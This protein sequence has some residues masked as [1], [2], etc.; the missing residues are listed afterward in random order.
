[1]KYST[2]PSSQ[3][4]VYHCKARGIK[5]I[6]ISP[7]SR[8]APLTIGFTEDPFFKCFSIVDERCAAFFALGIAQQL[9]EP[10]V[11]LCTSGSALLNYYPAISE[12]FYSDIPL[13]VISAD[14]PP[15]KVDVGDG[16]TIRQENVF[17]NHI[18]YG[19]NLKL[20]VSHA[21]DKIRKYDALSLMGTDVGIAQQ[22]V[23]EFNDTALD[24]AL[25]LAWSQ[26]SPVHINVPFEEPLYDV[27]TET[28]LIP[29]VNFVRDNQQ[30]L[31]LGKLKESVEVWNGS[32]RKIILVGVNFPN[33]VEQKYLEQL[34][35]DPSVIV[36]TECT[37]N[38]H[39][40]NFF[41]SIDSII[42]PIEKSPE[43]E[44]LFKQ[45]QPD[46][47]LTFG[48]LI[49]S[50]KIKAFL[51]EYSPKFHWHIDPQKAPNTFF[52]LTHHFQT[53]PNR[54]FEKLLQVSSG[55]QSDYQQYWT[56]FK[57][58]YIARREQYL[59]EIPFSDMLAFYRI[60]GSIPKDYQLQLG[61]S[62]TVRYGQL[63]DL[64]QCINVFCNRGTSGIDGSTS[65]AIGAALYSEQP[66]LLVTGDLSFLY[67]SNGLWNKYI[68]PDFRIIVINNGGGGIF[69][70]LPGKDKTDNF[71][72]FFETTHQIDLALIAKAY[73]FDF[74]SVADEGALGA[75]LDDF[76][77][78]SNCPKI[79]E[80]K[81]P[82]LLNDKI[83]LSYFDFISYNSK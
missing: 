79:L 2:I 15:Y 71:E 44:M 59:K 43:K 69:R 33:S 9:R 47:V 67:D 30:E 51:R 35:M 12:A 3:T 22:A 11:I 25:N 63:F 8:N 53:D 81:T 13:V 62:A 49:V 6:V 50:K 5:N 10:V 42:A 27:V 45:L 82:R 72:N 65:T 32:E 4:V 21:T 68:R 78:K 76:Y 57:N 61:N 26:N 66:T 16:Q 73:S 36:L 1:M 37:S 74:M 14:R 46:I 60:M 24:N 23:Q 52:S 39:H 75:V 38:L 64:D 70:I 41:P 48:G 18:A 54:F 56:R 19:A 20:D 80:I 58:E 31:D 29:M 40:H 77:A 83:L 55:I 34:A 17:E 7:G 28:T